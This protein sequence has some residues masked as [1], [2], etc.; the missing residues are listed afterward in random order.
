MPLSPY[1]HAGAAGREQTSGNALRGRR[2]A[3]RIRASIPLLTR[4]P[5]ACVPLGLCGTVT[6]SVA[7]CTAKHLPARYRNAHMHGQT[8][9]SAV[10]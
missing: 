9:T 5:P 10:P 4:S 3:E 2:D 1:H 8:P 6:P 7:M